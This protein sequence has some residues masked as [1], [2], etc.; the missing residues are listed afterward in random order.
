MAAKK[1]KKM[2]KYGRNAK[3][4]L[5]YRNAEHYEQNKALRML[6]HAARYGGV[7]MAGHEIMNCTDGRLKQIFNEFPDRVR[8]Y[9]VRVFMKQDQPRGLGYAT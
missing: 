3:S 8:R 5:A 1:S 2:R 4:C 7:S 6:K 9:A